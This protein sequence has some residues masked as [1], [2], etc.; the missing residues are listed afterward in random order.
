VIRDETINEIRE[1]VDIVAL[2]GE[3][4]RLKRMGQ[5]FKGLCPF[6][7]E[8]T[9]SFHVRQ[10]RRVFHCFGCG[11][12]GDAIGFVMR[13]EG[14]TF[15][16]AARMLAERAGIEIEHENPTEAANA[17]RVR[18]HKDRLYALLDAAAGFYV[19]QL[20]EHPL[21]RMA[22]EEYLGRAITD[23]TA[24]AFRLGYAPH[25]WDA[26]AT[27][28]KGQGFEPAEAEEVGLIVPRRGGGGHY[29]RFRHRLLFPIAD[30]T[31]RIVAF[32][33]RSLA[34]PP[35]EEPRAEGEAGAKYVN[36]P[37]GPLYKKGDMLFGL[38]EGR[39]SIRREAWAILCEGN[40]DLLALH[41]AGLSVAVAPL[42][43]AFTPGQAK[44]LRRYAERVV[45]L[46]DGDAAGRKAVRA[47]Q[48]LLRE[49]GLATT[50]V[51]LP[52]GEDPD[53]FLRKEGAD[54]LRRLIAAAPGIVEHII[55]DSAAACRG[56]A[57]AKA[58][59]IEALGPLLADVG[60]DNPAE[61][62]LYLQRLMKRFEIHDPEA[63]RRQLAKGARSAKN[64]A[65][66]RDA[67]AETEA[68]RPAPAPEALP[69][70]M[71]ELEVDV[72]G[73]LLDQPTL[74]GDPTAKR[75]EELLTSPDL[76]AILRAAAQ[77]MDE[78]GRLDGPALL[79]AVDGL[80][81]RDWLAGRI[82]VAQYED[83]HQAE[84]RLA[85]A[86]ARLEKDR[87]K[88][89][90]DSVKLGILEAV[91]RGDEAEAA[92]LLRRRNALVKELGT[93]G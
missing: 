19:R 13:L 48:P 36:S 8:K 70:H 86:R 73:A 77:M 22:R 71:P 35:G 32:S 63:L 61:V 45:L 28:L 3:Y 40:F 65:P 78:R 23:E 14:R 27:F 60:R 16:E 55:D 87:I 92:A 69:A 7:S 82:S 44:L 33:G 2:V 25:S 91:R 53:S 89:E 74:L 24:R 67:P 10:D 42:G 81:G 52:Q 50:V 17:Q 9:P 62:P 49:V 51:T 21:G 26:L 72:V 68:S 39:V 64:T 5:S 18:A 57:S 1:R 46:F 83:L 11:A 34:P 4:V 66:R 84:S 80:S 6:H 41:Q 54:A 29:D 12:S 20:R 43:T 90:M 76:R 79:A 59:A 88:R 56:D 15:P 31:G 38:H 93:L 85:Q 75:L 37:E 58:A 30:P 47:A